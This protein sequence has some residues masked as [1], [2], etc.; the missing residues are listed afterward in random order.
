MLRMRG[1][2]HAVAEVNVERTPKMILPAEIESAARELGQNLHTTTAVDDYL[3]AAQAVQNDPKAAAL[4]QQFFALYQRL[5]AKEQSGQILSQA[6]MSEYSQL[7][8]RVW[9]DPL[10]AARE[11]KL[12]VVKFSFADVGQ[13]ITSILG[14]DFS[15]LV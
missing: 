4:E 9:S 11:D 3:Q 2:A 6:E 12:Q 7:R 10:I 14:V 13:V 5:V 8:D 15:A 1:E